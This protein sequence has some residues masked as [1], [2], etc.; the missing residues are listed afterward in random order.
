MW[1]HCYLLFPHC[2]TTRRLSESKRTGCGPLRL[3]RAFRRPWPSTLLAA[4]EKSSWQMRGKCMVS[5]NILSMGHIQYFG[6]RT[7]ET[8]QRMHLS[9]SETSVFLATRARQFRRMR[10]PPPLPRISSPFLP[11]GA[12][13]FVLLPSTISFTQQKITTHLRVGF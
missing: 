12:S 4:G 5:V 13:S 7:V 2:R 8:T 9:A 10:P 1:I 11:S 6:R 3:T